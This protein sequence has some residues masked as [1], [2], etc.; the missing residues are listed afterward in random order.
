MSK[1][2]FEF[3]VPDG[4]H[5]GQAKDSAGAFRALLFDNKTGKLLGHAELHEVDDRTKKRARRAG[6]HDAENAANA[7]ACR[8]EP[9][10]VTEPDLPDME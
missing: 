4:Q 8:A 2:T 9:Q 10:G 7:P 5:L 3:D 6:S 1:R